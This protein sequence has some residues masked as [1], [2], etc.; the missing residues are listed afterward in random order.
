M[1]QYIFKSKKKKSQDKSLTTNNKSV[2][3]NDLDM[4]ASCCS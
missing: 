3:N 2:I 4:V 1:K